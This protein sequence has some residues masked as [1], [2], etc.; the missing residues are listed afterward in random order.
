M[1]KLYLIRRNLET[2]AGPM[3]S[4]ELKDAYKRMLFG[5][6]DE[7]SGH[8]G[9]W[10]TFDDLPQLRRFYPEI[11]KIVHED[12]ITGW[13]VS[14]HGS[15]IVRED[16][17]KLK[18][19]QQKGL[20]IALIF[21][22]VAL[23]AFMVALYF[24]T[25]GKMASRAKDEI[26]E[27]TPEEAQA[28]ID[29]GDLVGFDRYIQ[30]HLDYGVDKVIHSK[31]SESQWLM[32]L[33][34]FALRNEGTIPGLAPKVLRG[35]GATSA[36]VDCSLREWRRRWRASLRAWHEML[37]QHKL[38]RAHW[39]RLLAWDPYWIARRDAKGW[40]K[41]TTYYLMCVT[42]ANKALS[43]MV[44]DSTFTATMTEADKLGIRQMQ[45][46]LE[47]LTE[48]A[49]SG[50][51]SNTSQQVAL[52][53]LS[54]ISVWS[55]LEAARDLKEL[56]RCRGD[57]PALGTS[58]DPW[59]KYNEE[60]YGWNI[61][62]LALAQKGVLSSDFISQLN[63]YSSRMSR[64][65]FFSRFDY[66]YELKVWRTFLKQP[67]PVEKTIEKLQGEMVEPKP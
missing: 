8:C 46:R 2:F 66:R 38:V 40:S 27:P 39:S 65:D 41:G 30:E 23:G 25:A 63:Q 52:Q 19:S 62:R 15:N 20:V 16:T 22:G 21:L 4:A 67:F 18:V 45:Q 13:G 53:G 10:V 31:K 17:K 51:P 44:G 54:G 48:I 42:M 33:R 6:Q 34:H 11:A 61:L 50:R 7:V 57:M 56:A 47:W 28:Y 43:E 29:R 64:G 32:L 59:I 49:T 55:C 5:L 60:R 1:T 35:E 36:P 24:A 37:V 58:D 26:P 9:P 3:T 14:E 12:M